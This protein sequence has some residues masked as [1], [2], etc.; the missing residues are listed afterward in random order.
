MKLLLKRLKI[1]NT[2]GK[3]YILY[4]KLRKYYEIKLS[5]LVCVYMN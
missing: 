4:K 1:L 5:F 3:V 2:S